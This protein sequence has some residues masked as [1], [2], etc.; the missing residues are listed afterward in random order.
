MERNN[1]ITKSQHG[2]FSARSCTTQL[3]EFIKEATQALD[4]GEDVDVTYLDLAKTF[5]K[6]PHKTLSK[7]LSGYGIEGKV[8]G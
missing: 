1:L 6:V 7:K 2:F 5:D 3:L 4:R 8:T